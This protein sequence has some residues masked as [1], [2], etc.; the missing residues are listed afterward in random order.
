MQKSQLSPESG[1]TEKVRGCDSYWLSLTAMLFTISPARSSGC[2]LSRFIL[3]SVAEERGA[4]PISWSWKCLCQIRSNTPLVNTLHSLIT[5]R[6]CGK[7][8]DQGRFFGTLSKT[9]LPSV[10]SSRHS[11]AHACPWWQTSLRWIT[12]WGDFYWLWWGLTRVA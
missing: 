9:H 4:S 12:F 11:W 2:S 10:W 5:S 6:C 8:E 3:Q 7:L 1:N